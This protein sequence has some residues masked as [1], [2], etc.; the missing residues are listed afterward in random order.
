M[1]KRRRTYKGSLDRVLRNARGFH[2]GVLMTEKWWEGWLAGVTRMAARMV[3]GAEAAYR[4][5]GE[6]RQRRWRARLNPTTES[7]QWAKP[8][9]LPRRYTPR[10]RRPRRG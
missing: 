9:A 3:A 2:T 1:R 5:R 8:L 10:E 7:A 6:I 4:N